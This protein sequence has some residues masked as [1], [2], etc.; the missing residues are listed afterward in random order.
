MRPAGGIVRG[1]NLTAKLDQLGKASSGAWEH[2]KQ[3]SKAAWEEL[4]AVVKKAAAE[5]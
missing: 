4:E 5:F 1:F 2:L 3:G